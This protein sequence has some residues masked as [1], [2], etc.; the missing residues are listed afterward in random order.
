[1]KRL[2]V[3]DAAPILDRMLVSLLSYVPAQGPSGLAA[4]TAISDLRVEGR[5]VCAN[6]ILGPPLD[7][8]FTQ[9]KLAGIT[10]SQLEAVRQSVDVET[11]ITLGGV[12]V[13]NAGVYLCL[14]TIAEIIAG[15]QFVSWQDVI[16]T[17][18]ALL[19]AFQDAEEI[20]A[21]E[22][23]Q[24]SFQALITLHGALTNHLVATALPLPRMIGYQFYQ[25]LPT[26]VMAY[27]LYDDAS[28]CDELRAENN[29]V[30][31]AFCPL[32]GEALSA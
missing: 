18:T 32:A 31:P 14:A 12:R 23:D 6:D 19:P 17:K 21:D 7:D 13:K 26:L 22:M 27:K 30:H 28:R 9:A 1:M 25:P 4:R 15:T 2:E 20:A 8:C 3:N 10:W 24:A 29:I 11:P 5:H 16:A